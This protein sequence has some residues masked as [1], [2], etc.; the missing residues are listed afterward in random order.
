MLFL[1]EVLTVMLT[2]TVFAASV[3]IKADKSVG[4]SIVIKE[5]LVIEVVSVSLLVC[6]ALKKQETREKEYENNWHD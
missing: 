2:T 4:R 1:S 5:V 6:N 3:K